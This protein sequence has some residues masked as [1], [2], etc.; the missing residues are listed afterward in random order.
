MLNAYSLVLAV[1]FLSMGRVADR[2]GQKRVFIFGLV[3]F[4]LFSLLCG[5]APTIDWLI[6]FRAG[7]GIGGAALLTISLA[8]VLG[9]FPQRQQGMAVGHLGRARHRRRGRRTHARRPA[10]HLRQLALDLL[11]QRADRHRSPSS[12]AP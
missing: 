7:Q 10:R 2:Y 11:R 9:A 1:F 12:S 3:T 5:F 4:T 8:I 6:A